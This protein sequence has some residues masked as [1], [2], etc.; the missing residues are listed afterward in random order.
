MP[1]WV[2][3]G[4]RSCSDLATGGYLESRTRTARPSNPPSHPPVPCKSSLHTPSFHSSLP[5]PTLFLT[6]SH[7]SLTSVGGTTSF[8]PEVAVD[9]SSGGFS[10]LFPRPSYQDD[11]VRRYLDQLGDT[12]KGLFNTSGRAFPDIAAQA[13]AFQV[14]RGGKTI[15]VSGTSAASPTVA[16]LVALL[17][18]VIVG[19]GGKPLGFLNPFLYTAGAAALNDITEGSNPGCGTDGFPAAKGWDPVRTT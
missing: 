3:A 6:R 5:L 1:S 15:S 9:F 11:A 4:P 8:G 19:A 16:G 7:T 18:D 17:N 14:V 10:N 12:H 13:R 2:R